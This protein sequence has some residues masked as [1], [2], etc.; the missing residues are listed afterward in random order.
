MRGKAAGNP[1][2]IH[3]VQAHNFKEYNHQD[4]TFLSSEDALKFKHWMTSDE[5]DF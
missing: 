5:V 1:G 4:T 2:E 3:S